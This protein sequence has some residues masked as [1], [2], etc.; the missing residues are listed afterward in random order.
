MIL[1]GDKSVIDAI[2][3]KKRLMDAGESHEHINILCIIDGG[4]MKG[5]YSAGA[6]LALEELGYTDV[7]NTIVG[8]SSGAPSA[9]YF[10]AGQVH[11][12]ASLIYEECCDKDFFKLWRFPNQLN[13]G[14]LMQALTTGDK[15]LDWSSIEQSNTKLFAGVSEF[16]TGKPVLVEASNEEALLS[17]IEASIAIPTLCNNR[18]EINGVRYTDGGFT[19]PHI[20]EHCLNTI[21]STHMIVFT[22]Q[23]KHTPDIPLH[24]KLLNHTL[25]RHRYSAALLRAANRRRKE[26]HHLVERILAGEFETPICLVWGNGTINSTDRRSERVKAVVE[27]SRDWWRELLTR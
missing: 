13:V 21:P 4:L 8:V 17:A 5:A 24:E 23:D 7:F 11:K 22:S 16:A 25:L 1:E 10:V 19:A 3:E 20:A 12:G 15:K 18:V 26:R 14:F 2:K 27:K 9:A 6:G